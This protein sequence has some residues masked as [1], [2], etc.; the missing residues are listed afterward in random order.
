MTEPTTVTP[1]E[2]TPQPD[3]PQPRAAGTTQDALSMT[4]VELDALIATEKRQAK[5]S[6]LKEYGDVDA[7]KA[8]AAKLDQLEKDELSEIE[9]LQ[10]TIKD[11]E[12]AEV[13][14]RQAADLA[15]L[16]TLRLRVGQEAGLPPTL[17]ARLQ[18]ADEDALKADAQAILAVMKIEPGA[19][20]PNIDATAG[21]GKQGSGA[22]SH[23][24]TPEQIAAAVKANIPLDTYAKALAQVTGE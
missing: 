12:A 8:K 5:L 1:P 17:S 18:G 2:V 7:L 19:R 6:V 21:G 4:Q 3:S 9:K 13:T 15:T 24:L 22:A 11:M 10:K 23:D 16:D 20:V 14:L